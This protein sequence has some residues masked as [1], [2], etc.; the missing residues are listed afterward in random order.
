[1]FEEVSSQKQIIFTTHN[2]EACGMLAY[3]LLLVARDGH[4]FV[5]GRMEVRETV[6]VFLQMNWESTTCMSEA[7]LAP[8]GGFRQ[9]L[10]LG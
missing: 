5:G 1:M 2:P 10:H 8:M 7:S 4:G 9:L 6:K 3:N